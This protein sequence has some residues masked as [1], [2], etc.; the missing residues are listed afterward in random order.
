MVPQAQSTA[1]VAVLLVAAQTSLGFFLVLGGVKPLAGFFGWEMNGIFCRGIRVDIGCC[2]NKWFI[3]VRLVPCY[4]VK[5]EHERCSKISCVMFRL[6]WVATCCHVDVGYQ[7]RD[8]SFTILNGCGTVRVAKANQGL[9]LTVE[10]A[11]TVPATEPKKRW[12]ISTVVENVTYS[13]LS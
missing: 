12:C 5:D 7:D 6:M 11:K 2:G 13:T 3:Y 4:L 1:E 9:S 8:R 10:F